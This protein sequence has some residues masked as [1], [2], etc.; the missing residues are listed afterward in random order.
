MTCSSLWPVWPVPSGLALAGEKVSPS[1][2]LQEGYLFIYLF[3]YL[4]DVDHFLKSL[5]NLLQDCFCF[6][7]CFVLFLATGHMRS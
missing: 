1:V 3:I 5:L 2:H 7:F 6:M 4:F